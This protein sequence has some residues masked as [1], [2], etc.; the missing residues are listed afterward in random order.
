MSKR[1]PKVSI[2]TVSYNA[3]HEI[4][5]TIQSVISQTYPNIEYIIIDGQ[6][7]DDTLKKIEPYKALL[8]SV[9]TERDNGLYHAMNKGLDKASG[10]WIGF[11]NAGDIYHSS[12][13][14]S[15]LIN[16]ER[17][18]IDI[19]FGKSITKF[20]DLQNIRHLDF[21]FENQD[22]YVKRMPN[23]QAIL[24]HKNVY[25]KERFDES[26]RYFADT[27]YLR[28]IFQL[29]RHQYVDDIIS[30]FELGGKSSYNRELS[31]L[32]QMIRETTRINGMSF[33]KWTVHIVKFLMAV[34]L[35]KSR[36]L[37]LYI[38]KL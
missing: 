22:W 37:S 4:E 15:S 7:T 21:Q 10:D 12:D 31:V 2:V 8:S 19:L 32:I 11:M 29:Y 24:V 6:S 38:K 9:I 3:E 20:G 36:Y 23:H 1:Q 25:K 27:V 26:F 18:G 16:S 34:I 28:K 13:A 14:V 35:P 33:R 5:R 17:E 30:E